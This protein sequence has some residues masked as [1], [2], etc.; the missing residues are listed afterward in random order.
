MVGFVM[1]GHI[2]WYIIIPEILDTSQDD[3]INYNNSYLLSRLATQHVGTSSLCPRRS[4]LAIDGRIFT[5]GL[6]ESFS[7]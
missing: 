5:K 7:T 4:I 2:Y 3:K 6:P 1:E